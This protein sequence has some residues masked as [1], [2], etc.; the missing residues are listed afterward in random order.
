VRRIL[1]VDDEPQI[2][3]AMQRSL[4]RR[5]ADWDMVFAGS[6]LEA[7]AALTAG[8][9]DVVVSDGRMP[10]MDGIALLEQIKAEYPTTI[11]IML[12]GH[13]DE[14]AIIPALPAIHQF[15]SKP[16]QVSVLEAV[17][18][19]ALEASRRGDTEAVREALLTSDWL[20]PAP[21]LYSQLTQAL[22]DPDLP[23][24]RIYG[25]VERD[26]SLT[27]VLLKTVNSAYFGLP[28]QVSSVAE[29][30]R[31]LGVVVVRC[32]A[33][34][35]E[36]FNH[37]A[38]DK[39]VDHSYI[40]SFHSHS[41]LTA[42]IARGL[43]SGGVLAPDRVFSAGLL[44]DMGELLLATRLPHEGTRAPRDPATTG[45]QAEQIGPTHAEIGGW[46]LSHWGLPAFLVETASR[47]HGPVAFFGSMNDLTQVI[48]VADCLAVE[49]VPG[50][51]GLPHS[52]IEAQ[53]ITASGG[54]QR[55]DE[56]R[57]LAA[58]VAAG[59]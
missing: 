32:L 35:V 41:F 47:H 49:L 31:L 3:R 53:L 20:P 33:L 18:E 1:F 36:A 16:C 4:R 25:L 13:A 27:A 28:R 51:Q 11:R 59:G 5:S 23:M 7:L 55:L 34:F 52:V 48:H 57:K 10:E 12:S 42:R 46:L 19:S 39:H 9:F 15:L 43:A 17:L 26:A 38:I 56:W 14:E 44:H 2:L 54:A 22:K 37:L 50:A 8:H 45:H 24:A 30:A 6:A 29:A 21:R 58:R 40:E